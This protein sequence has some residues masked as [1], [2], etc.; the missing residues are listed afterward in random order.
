MVGLSAASLLYIFEMYVCLS[1]CFR[2]EL[3]LQT[4]GPISAVYFVSSDSMAKEVTQLQNL[5]IGSMEALHHGYV[6]QA[7]SST[8][9][10]FPQNTLTVLLIL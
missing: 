6:C 10:H 1:V 7:S 5:Q 8:I 4:A 3:I 2:V 9:A